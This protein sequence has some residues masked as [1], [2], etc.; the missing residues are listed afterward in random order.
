MPRQFNIG[1]LLVLSAIIIVMTKCRKD[2]FITDSSAKLEFSRDTVLFD[3]IFTTL[4]STT[5]AFKV[6]NTHSQRIKISNIY[7]NSGS[8]SRY[9]INVDGVSA[10]E[11]S[12]VE[13]AGNDSM[14]VFVEVT[15]DP[16]DNTQ[17]IVVEDDIVFLTNGNT[18]EV[19]LLAWGQDAIFHF[20]ADGLD[21]L[22]CD[23]VWT[24]E[25]PHVLM[26]VV[27]VA[28]CCQL[29]IEQGT[30]V[31]CHAGTGI[32]VDRGTLNVEGQLGQ[33]VVFQGDRLEEEYQNLSGQ[34]GIEIDFEYETDFGI[35]VATI[36]RGGIWLFQAKEC[37][38]NYAEI[39]N[40]I[41]GIQVDTA[42]TP[43]VPA[44]TLSNTKIYNMSAI[45]LYAQGGSILGYND[46]IANCGQACGAFTI[47]GEYEFEHCS[48]V[49]Y[50]TESNRQS[51]TFVL[52]NYYEDV[53]G[54]LQVRT[55]Q[56]TEFRNCFMY[57]NNAG[58][59]DFSEFIVDMEDEEFQDYSFTGCYVDT[60]IDLS[61]GTIYD[62]MKNN[63]GDPLFVDAFAMEF[64]VLE[65]AGGNHDG[66][67]IPVPLSFSD[68][69]GQFRSGAA[70]IGCYQ[71]G[72]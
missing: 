13:I 26:S 16:N 64:D 42:Y 18:Q 41:I 71:K 58:L 37:N 61:D 36:T 24:N 25:L 63:Q 23:E 29:T 50:W 72:D 9:R 53:N 2:D 10:D 22:D 44:L 31:Y 57:G 56:N 59:S 3:T 32:L 51:P 70:T 6:Y 65:N 38:I 30:Q 68:I 7:I 8:G 47:G 19:K 45:G 34:W 43:G 35:E 14:F 49:N 69:E 60:D 39:K 20:D 21:V 54:N 46:L 11:H 28:D 55:I 17:P 52:N 1:L 62:N 5:Q 4:G 15:L 27:G 48:F 66:S 67:S 33:E 40:G 12:D